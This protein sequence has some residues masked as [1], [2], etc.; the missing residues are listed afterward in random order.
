MVHTKAGGIIHDVAL[1][2]KTLC[3]KLLYPPPELIWHRF[4][5]D[6]RVVYE[7]ICDHRL[8]R[9]C[10]GIKNFRKDIIYNKK[11]YAENNPTGLS[12]VALRTALKRLKIIIMNL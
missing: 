12:F 9:T 4:S 2:Y 7:V 3:I 8:P 10:K 5:Q 11:R 1:S 6:M